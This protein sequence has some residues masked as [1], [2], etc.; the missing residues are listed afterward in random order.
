MTNKTH[1]FAST[2]F[3]LKKKM[4]TSFIYAVLIRI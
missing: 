1:T 4:M 3:S 2:Y